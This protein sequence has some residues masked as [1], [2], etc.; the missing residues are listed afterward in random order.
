MRYFCVSVSIVK[1]FSFTFSLLLK[2]V[3]MM[4][5]KRQFYADNKFDWCKSARFINKIDVLCSRFS[6]DLFL[7][8]FLELVF[9]FYFC[10]HEKGRKR[11]TSTTR[12]K[13]GQLTPFHVNTFQNLLEIVGPSIYSKDY[14]E[15]Y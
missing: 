7:G 12:I 1:F 14:S 3:G 10:W 2:K 13:Y 15:L 8:R 11:T 4:K 5:I 6:N 9:F